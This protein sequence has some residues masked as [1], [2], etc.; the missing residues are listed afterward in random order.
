MK[1]GNEKSTRTE[2]YNVDATMTE[3][4]DERAWGWSGDAQ[5]AGLDSVTDDEGNKGDKTR[6]MSTYLVE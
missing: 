5:A 6:Q 4:L 2:A 1:N 3:S